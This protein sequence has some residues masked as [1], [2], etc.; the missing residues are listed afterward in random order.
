MRDKL[1]KINLTTAYLIS[2]PL[3]LIAAFIAFELP[4]ILTRDGRYAS[5]L[6][7]ETY[8]WSILGLI[9][10]FYIA[11][12]YGSKKAHYM[13]RAGNNLLPTSFKFSLIIN[14]IVWITFSI[15]A[16]I[17]NLDYNILFVLI[18][19]IVAFF[20]SVAITTFTIGLLI[21]YLFDTRIKKEL[22]ATAA[23]NCYNK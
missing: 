10:S 16:I 18:F 23:N 1:L 7:I 8:G 19:P 4:I 5:I 9:L 3:G 15:I 13:L 17:D 14:C 2:I 20:I 11:I 6:I 12:W 21:V 22:K